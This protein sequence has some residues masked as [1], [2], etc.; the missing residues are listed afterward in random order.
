MNAFVK[1]E[2]RLLLPSWIAIMSLAALLPW[3]SWKNPDEGFTSMPLFLFFGMVLLAVDSFGREFSAGTFS[4][5]MSQPI[6]RHQVW[7]TKITILISAT[8]LISIAYFLSSEFL[9]HHALKT[10]IWGGSKPGIAIITGN[11]WNSML[12]SGVAVLIALAGGLWATLLLRQIAAAFWITFLI[13]LGI[14]MLT[15]LFMPE[16]IPVN[17]VSILLY[18]M[19]VIYSLA[20]FWFAHRL[21][22]R[23]QDTAWTGGVINFSTWRY[24][25]ARDTNYVSQRGQKPFSALLKKE[26]HLHS[27]SLL[28]A[29][30]LAALHVSVFILRAFDASHIRQ[31]QN[32]L[33]GTISEF[34][35][36]LWLIMPLTIGCMA[37]SEERKLGKMDGQ[38]CLP[39]SRRRQFTF[40][41]IPVLFSGVLLGGI[42]PLL[43]ETVAAFFGAP[44]DYFKPDNH[45][46]D[47]VFSGVGWFYFCV[48]VASAGLA[49][50]GLLASTMAKNFMQALSIAI[51]G[52]G[53]GFIFKTFLTNSH[54]LG[55]MGD[56]AQIGRQLWGVGLP[57]LVGIVAI[58]TIVPWLAWRNYSYF[59]E[60]GRLWRRNLLGITGAIL[61]VFAGSAAIYNRA[62]EFLEPAEPAHGTAKLTLSSRAILQSDGRDS[63]QVRLPDGRVWFDSLEGNP[64]W[65]NQPDNLRELWWA[66]I[67]PL[68]KSAG[69]QQFMSRSNWISTT[70]SRR[71]D[72][73]NHNEFT[74][75]YPDTV[76][77]QA[78]GSLWISSPG[79]TNVWTGTNM[80]RFDNENNWQQAVSV[81]DFAF[82]LLKT[83]GTLWRWQNRQVDWNDWRNWRTN[84]P[85]VRTVQ[86]QQ[87]GTNSDWQEIF[88][89]WNSLARKTNGSVWAVVFERTNG[90]VG[91]TQETNLD[92]IAPQTA[93]GND[94]RLYVSQTGNLWINR[95]QFGT[96]TNWVKVA[97][98]WNRA[99]ALKSDGSL[100]QW[101]FNKLNSYGVRLGI[102]NDWVGLTAT[103]NGTISLAAD[104]SLWFWPGQEYDGAL[105][106]ATRK[107]Q[108]LANVFS[109][110]D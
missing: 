49:M 3:L 62:W 79:E 15:M 33:A 39:V 32:S 106:K 38:F 48:I 55:S 42:M 75:I 20:G 85:S 29:C 46:G 41:F 81:Q 68:L 98:S 30:A 45:A 2:I 10:S 18:I 57:V 14:L 37:V 36:S 59:V 109:Q 95:I 35:W 63:L 21:F 52:I 99:V 23:S 19:A 1:K 17:I 56:G 83:D 65:G 72:Y 60:G 71:A 105:L 89:T 24:F 34:F 93:Y 76:G 51:A 101:D 50:L 87:I 11:F 91:L 8:A 9:F 66:M 96:E 77:V 80:I 44:N 69:P 58:V 28:C 90:A 103:W 88:S 67:P 16:K 4:S 43:L 104:G 26:F 102:H 7:R 6:E 27:L 40:K 110:G 13:P 53:A 64:Y 74:F 100:W 108:F 5:L 107:P 73:W 70:I 86:P 25:N 61:F 82:L 31:D 97:E 22:Q 54:F 92:L 12:N 84:M 78:D 94:N 47:I